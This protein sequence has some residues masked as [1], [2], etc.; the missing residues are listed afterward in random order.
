MKRIFALILLLALLMPSAAL[1]SSSYRYYKPPIAVYV[2]ADRAAV[3]K[4]PNTAAPV[5]G[6]PKRGERFVCFA[7]GNGWAMLVNS[8]GKIGYCQKS[9]LSKKPVGERVWV[10]YAMAC[11]V[12]LD[13]GGTKTISL[14]QEYELIGTKGRRSHIRNSKGET[15]WC[16]SDMLSKTDPN[17]L[18]ETLYV[19][20]SGAKLF[21]QT[22]TTAS[23]RTLKRGQAVT[24]VARKGDWYRVKA[25]GRY[26]YMHALTLD[27]EKAPADGRTLY[28]KYDNEPLYMNGKI[29]C[30]P[31]KGEALKLKGVTQN[32]KS[33]TVETLDG[34]T[35]RRGYGFF[36]Y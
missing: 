33:L 20:C 23:A 15:G 24:A 22:V 25:G 16:D 30:R 31:M 21:S 10:D 32:G 36:E 5:L 18:N 27:G 13:G 2:K 29:V 6:R 17:R 11:A 1:A 26:G 19:Q 35:G 14:G 12:E 9:L 8:K 7:Q 3:Y 4:Q 34:I 28:W